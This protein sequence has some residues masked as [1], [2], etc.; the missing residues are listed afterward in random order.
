MSR[1][2]LLLITVLALLLLPVLPGTASAGTTALDI[3]A[4]C[5]ET[6]GDYDVLFTIIN[7]FDDSVDVVVDVYEVDLSNE[8]RPTFSPNPMPGLGQSTASDTVPGTTMNIYMEVELEGEFDVSD[9]QD[10]DG[11]CA[12]SPTTTTS[13]TAAA[14]PATAAPTTTAAAQPA[15]I[16]P[17]FTG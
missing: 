1:T 7:G 11:D 8:T 17:T 4:T 12:P 6:T 5:N 13:T 9:D 14:A 10:L 16:Q 2:R 15:Q 3:H